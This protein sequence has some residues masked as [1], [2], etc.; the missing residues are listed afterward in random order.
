M[1][2]HIPIEPAVKTIQVSINSRG[3]STAIETNVIGVINISNKM[4]TP[5]KPQRGQKAACQLYVSLEIF[6]TFNVTEMMKINIKNLANSDTRPPIGLQPSA[7]SVS[8]GLA[9]CP[10]KKCMTY[11]AEYGIVINCR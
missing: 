7:R 9:Q 3:R 2:L 6:S 4:R 11:P 1:K 5:S 8:S 10:S